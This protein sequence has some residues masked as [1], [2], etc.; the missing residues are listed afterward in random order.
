MC[1]G[2]TGYKTWQMYDT[3]KNVEDSKTNNII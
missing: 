2:H 1:D 3:K